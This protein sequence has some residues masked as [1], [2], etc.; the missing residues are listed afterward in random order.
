[1][2]TSRT[3]PSP[4]TEAWA[5]VRASY[6]DPGATPAITVERIVA[7][8]DDDFRAHMTGRP[9]AQ[10]LQALL[11]AVPKLE[12]AASDASGLPSLAQAVREAARSAVAQ[13][14]SASLFGELAISAAMK[15]VLA[16]QASE[17]AQRFAARYAADVLSYLVSRDITRHTGAGAFRRAADVSRF[18]QGVEEHVS[19]A[20]AALDIAPPRRDASPAELEAFLAQAVEAGLNALG[21]AAD[22]NAE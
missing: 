4:R 17:P 21:Q 12:A 15:C 6:A 19:R 8:L 2:G 5:K 14:S 3:Q 11:A 10:A 20:V 9:V 7:A 18:V 22:E 16:G 1:M 13:E